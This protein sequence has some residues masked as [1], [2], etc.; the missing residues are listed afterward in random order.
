MYIGMEEDVAESPSE[1]VTRAA[2][3]CAPGGAFDQT[4][5]YPPLV[6]STLDADSVPM[7]VVPSR[8]S[9]RAIV[10]GGEVEPGHTLA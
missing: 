8:K 5:A 4:N 6:G 1:S 2:I 3:W 10:D 9:T 7:T